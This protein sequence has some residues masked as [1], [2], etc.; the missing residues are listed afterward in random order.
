MEK[1]PRVFI[2]YSHNDSVYEE[3]IL[4]FSNKL[5]SEGIDA[6][7]DLYE[8]SPSEGWPRWMEN[9]INESDYVLIVASREYYEKYYK[10]GGKGVTW[11]VSIIY[12]HLYDSGAK[13]SK[14]IPVFFNDEDVQ[15][16]PT[17]I[18]QFT[19]YNVGT[20]AGYEKLYWRLRGIKKTEKPELGKLR[21][22][23]R[24]EQKTMFFTTPIEYERWNKAKWSGMLY[25]FFP[26]NDHP[27][28]LGIIFQNYEEGK[29]IF[30]NWQKKSNSG[31]CDDFLRFDFVE[32]PFPKECY[33]NNEKLRNYGKGYFV[34]IGANL[35]ESYKRGLELG[36]SRD[37]LLIATI[38]RYQWMD[39]TDRG[40]KRSDFKKLIESG[41]E[42]EVYP[43]GRKNSFLPLTKDN[44]IIGY[45][46]AIKMKKA[47]F[48]PAKEIGEYDLCSCVL[49]KPTII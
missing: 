12:Q 47:Y 45:D 7:V 27:P 49:K 21:P 11:E 1:N 24:K 46:Y 15:Y 44:V 23:P 48:I 6:N 35:N 19:Y 43:I 41:S 4:S 5:R 34:H 32:P 37:D 25:L 38:S 9:Q 42:F 36:V 18:K 16:I 13:T 28:V 26:N 8:E 3:K 17:P 10:N 29:K 31:Y 20:S 14:F 33:V 22:L 30:T 2:S 40:T 39:E